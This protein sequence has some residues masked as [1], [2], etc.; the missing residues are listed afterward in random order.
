[1]KIIFTTV[2]ELSTTRWQSNSAVMVM[3][4]IDRKLAEQATALVASR[5]GRMVSGGDKISNDACA[6]SLLLAVHDTQQQGFVATLNQAF[7]ATQSPLF[8]YLAQDAFAGRNWLALALQ[9][10]QSQTGASLLAF[11]DGKW[12][13]QLAS[14]GLARRDWINKVYTDAFFFQGYHSHFADAE[15]T[16]VARQQGVYTYEPQSLLV[17][18]DWH[19]DQA[20]VND[21]DRRLFATRKKT[22][23]GNRV[24]DPQWLNLIA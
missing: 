11:N 13:G 16:L 2:N 24:S 10:L 18:V 4:F 22:G 8:G 14:F 9:K 21:A 12:Q 15:L 3:P 17:E 23:F 5:S 19:K 6:Q 7:A 20:A 1:M